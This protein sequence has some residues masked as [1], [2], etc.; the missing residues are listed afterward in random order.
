MSEDKSHEKVLE[1]VKDAA[2]KV[3][4]LATLV[5]QAFFDLIAWLVPGA[6]MIPTI[7]LAAVG[8]F[9][10]REFI[11][12]ALMTSPDN[13]PPTTLIVV[14]GLVLA[15]TLAMLLDGIW[16]MGAWVAKQLRQQQRPTQR[17]LY[18]RIKHKSQAMGDVILKM[19]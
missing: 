11:G 4:L 5:P 7:T 15:Y 1:P 6:F 16:N 18:H 17:K 9:K 19:K 8:P 2:E 3:G 12:A 10:F 14:V 13:Y